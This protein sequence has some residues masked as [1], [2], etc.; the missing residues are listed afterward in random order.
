[1]IVIHTSLSNVEDYDILSY[2]YTGGALSEPFRVRNGLLQGCTLAPK[3][4]NIFLVLWC[5][6]G[7][8]IVLKLV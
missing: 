8:L 6:P 2:R 7:G 5:L 4:F 1:M 3:L